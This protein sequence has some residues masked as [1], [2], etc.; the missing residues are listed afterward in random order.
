VIFGTEI[1]RS[2]IISQKIPKHGNHRERDLQFS[3]RRLLRIAFEQNDSDKRKVANLRMMRVAV[4]GRGCV[5]AAHQ[6][7]HVI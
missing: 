6:P 3:A 5:C 1:L 2:S 7:Q 4:T